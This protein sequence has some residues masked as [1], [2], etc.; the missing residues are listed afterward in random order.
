MGPLGGCTQPRHQFL[1]PGRVLRGV[2]EPGEEVERLPEVAAVVELARDGRQ[3][4]RADADVVRPLLEQLAALVLSECPP[5]TGLRDGDQRRAGRSGPAELRLLGGQRVVLAAPGVTQI[6]RPSAQRP[7][8][9]S[10]V[11]GCPVY[12]GHSGDRRESRA[13]HCFDAAYLPGTVA[14]A[15]ESGGRCWNDA[16]GV[17][18]SQP[19]SGAAPLRQTTQPMRPTGPRGGERCRRWHRGQARWGRR[20]VDARRRHGG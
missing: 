8:A 14:A 7:P 4:L 3:V 1:E 12:Y 9:R 13:D 18:A 2:L 20:R 5:G 10:G 17:L 15:H 19:V 16:Q 6:A 11:I